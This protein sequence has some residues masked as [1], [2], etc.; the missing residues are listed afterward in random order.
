MEITI[1]KFLE[2][3]IIMMK[4]SEAYLW[5]QTLL[6]PSW[7]PPSWIFGPVWT[8]LYLAIAFTF[9]TVL[10]EA[11]QKTIP[12]LVALPF[13]LNLLF[14][15]AFTP[16]QFGLRSNVL[17]AVDIA[18]VLVTLIWALFAV[19]PYM[20]FVV[21]ANLPYLAWVLFA[22]ALQFTITYLNTR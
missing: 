10:V 3:T 18:L 17:A 16:L 22:S 7:A 19:W 11:F 2:Y 4:T 9:G 20:R 8:L 1:E 21:Y 5:Y 14:N 13:V 15:F 12:G 6:K